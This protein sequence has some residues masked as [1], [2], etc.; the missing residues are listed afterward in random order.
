MSAAKVSPEDLK[1][2]AV[3][4]EQRKVIGTS[5]KRVEDPKLLR[6]RGRYIDD[7]VLDGMLHA[8]VLRSPHPHARI[9]SIDA[10][11][12]RRAPGVVAVM[13]GVEAASY[14]A[15]IPEAGPH[16]DKHVWRVL[17]A[18]KVR[19][20]GEGVAVVV[21]EN[22]YLAED[23]RE[24]IDVTYEL[25]EPIV[26]PLAAAEDA[27]NLVHDLLET[28][29][30]LEHTFAFGN[31]DEVFAE[32][33]L[34]VKD[35]LRWRRSA[36]TPLD[37]SGAVA[38]Y[39]EG[40][41]ELTIHSNS[42]SGTTGHFALAAALGIPGN[43]F[44]MKPYYAG[45]S[46]GAKQLCWRAA[47]TA[48]M[49]AKYTGR[50]V[51]YVE[52]RL[53]HTFN[54][55]QVGSDRYYEVELAVMRTGE[56]KGLKI[57]VVDDY[58]AYIQFG[59]ASHGNAMAQPT[60]P[61]RMRALKYH[62]R[63]VLTNKTQQ[64]AYRGFGTDAGNWVLER[65]VD[66]AA[67]EL[68]MDPTEMRR[69]NFIQPDEF[70][71]RAPGG[72][73][74]DSG[75]YEPVL[76]HALRLLDYD[77]WREKQAQMRAAGRHV[78]IGVAT[79]NERSVYGPTEFW[80]WSDKVLDGPTSSPE[81]VR[82]SIDAQASFTVTL[83]SKPFEGNSPDTV[84]SMLVAE[85][86]DI[87]PHHVAVQH[88]GSRGG[89]PAAGPGGSRLTV[90][91][92]GAVQGASKVLKDKMRL[93]AAHRLAVKKDDLEWVDGG[94]QLVDLPETR[95]SLAQLAEIAHFYKIDLPEGMESAL[96]AS[97]VYDHP[98][99]TKPAADRSDL[100]IFYPCVGH[101]CHL[102][103]VEA[104]P[105]TGQ[106]TIL[107]Y[108]AVHDSGVLVN[109]RSYDGQIV[110]GTAQ[111][112]ATTLSEEFAFDDAGQ[113]LTTTFWDYLMPT[114]MDV[115]EMRIGHEETPSPITANG[116]KGGGEAGRLMAP[117]AL[118]SAIDDALREYGVRVLDLP[119]TPE[120]ITNMIEQGE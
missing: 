103:V 111:G 61:Y 34:V 82:L 31:P 54:G 2:T 70:P 114:A 12:A 95:L 30:A 74:Y 78:G 5:I 86:F 48:A 28:N 60:G 113:P 26:D 53:D 101:A 45:G 57:D 80:F 73:M 108:A 63:A 98:F 88:H 107:D 4:P 23:A 69:M 42:L 39:D 110:G 118:S 18:D 13:T 93:I 22:R 51:K 7:V 71:Y 90:M 10:E 32:A 36:G 6:G 49:M 97:F 55:D 117:S 58:G 66:K 43:K 1:G 109:P 16:P 68:G 41:G 9:V 100:G 76:D 25:L 37:T 104:D 72:N 8:V 65:M 91:L 81:G 102:A 35:R 112:I 75:N 15:P 106:V 62:V 21:A 120:R 79:C 29:V 17:A 115:P 89:L 38:E 50:P 40:T 85:E 116:V 119:A 77:G 47:L 33:D 19:Y 84:A 52:D 99:L 27:S 96:D 46:F 64:G 20:V 44:D 67:A 87:D 92:A 3:P 59:V 83:F 56:L 24:L 14:I 94:F 11:R 105:E